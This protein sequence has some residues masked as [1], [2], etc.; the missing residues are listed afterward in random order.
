MSVDIK[1]PTF[2]ESVNDGVLTLWHKQ[3]EEPVRRDEPLADVETDKIT[4]EISA[5]A[6]GQLVRILAPAGSTVVSDQVLAQ[7]EPGPAPSDAAE[8]QAAGADA[9]AAGADAQAAGADAQAAGADAQAAGGEPDGGTP[10]DERAI[11]PAARALMAERGLA[12]AQVTS[13][14]SARI[15]KTDVLE[16]LAH[17][18]SEP[19]AEA[20]PAAETMSAA[21]PGAARARQ[22]TRTPMSRMRAR[23][24]ERMLETTNETAMLTTFN[25]VDMQPLMDLRKQINPTLQQRGDVK[26]GLMSFFVRALCGALSRF[27]MVNASLD[28][29]DIVQRNYCDI[30]VAVSTERGLMTPVLKDADTMGL[31]C[32]ERRVAE[33][34]DKARSGK[35]EL[36]DITGGTFT[37]TNGGVFGSMLSTPLLNPPQTAILGMHAIQRRPVAR[38]AEHGGEQVVVAP[39][40]YL[41]LSYDHR[42]I[43]GREAV[44]F[45]LD[46]K[47]S[48]EQP[49]ILLMEP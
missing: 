17:G 6:D 8:A 43:D 42:L 9:Q 48:L 22:E 33:L 5:P 46:V 37:L 2:P 32:I 4:L 10:A 31:R 41:A 27:P 18:S 19:V 38:T 14:D 36:A 30:S 45:L 35:I 15:T 13:H 11:N 7:F 25:E 21:G 26:I 28:G 23:I 39:M 1:A 20:M 44:L 29:G 24:A 12:A 34:A 47:Q 49:L 3:P 16:A 40:M